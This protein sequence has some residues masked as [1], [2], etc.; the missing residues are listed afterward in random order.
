MCDVLCAD[1]VL[2]GAA[3]SGVI[4]A[5]LRL[6]TLAGLDADLLPISKGVV[7]PRPS[8]LPLFDVLP[9]RATSLLCVRPPRP[10]ILLTGT[11]L[12]LAV[13]SNK[14]LPPVSSRPEEPA[15]SKSTPASGTSFH[16]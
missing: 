4:A 8:K 5:G 3:G 7:L 11:R 16:V 12:P 1:G 6:T 2:P 14:K 13:L 10:E 9:I 15:C